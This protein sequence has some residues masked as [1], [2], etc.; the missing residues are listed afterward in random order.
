MKPE[1][2]RKPNTALRQE[3]R[4]RGWSQ[5]EVARQL[6]DIAYQ[7]VEGDVVDFSF[8][9]GVTIDMVSKWE[10][11]VYV[12]S[13]FYQKRLCQLFQR[14]AAELGLMDDLLETVEKVEELTV[15][16]QVPEQL[17]IKTTLQQTYDLTNTNTILTPPFAFSSIEILERLAQALA[18]P[19]QI[20]EATLLGLEQAVKDCW[21]FRPDILGMISPDF[22]QVPLD[23][24]QKVTVLLSG[25]LLPS[26]RVR[27]CA[28]A[29]ELTQIIAWTL[30]EMRMFSQAQAYYEM[31]LVAARE[32]GDPLLEAVTLTRMSRVF[33]Y[34][35]QEEA[36]LPAIQHA[37]NLLAY[38]NASSTFSWI[39][40]E[41]ALGY[42]RN[43]Q[44]Y[45]SLKTLDLVTHVGQPDNQEEDPYWVGFEE[46]VRAGFLGSCYTA[47]QQFEKAEVCYREALAQLH[48]SSRINFRHRRSLLLVNLATVLLNKESIEEACQLSQ[49]ALALVDQSKSPLVLQHVV[50]FKRKLEPWKSLAAVESFVAQFEQIQANLLKRN[51][52]TYEK[53]IMP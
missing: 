35:A 9:G 19:T 2:S 52:W 41:E 13:L 43:E 10:L 8:K 53:G 36:V 17:Q 39:C 20:D 38:R 48:P 22:L 11:G 12:P 4:L 14:T 45:E 18:R 25:S 32:T 33:K 28:I 26:T 27:L 1:N 50:K 29:C 51:K 31:A 7:D 16:C 24:L 46:N 34:C 42:A 44:A 15:A 5:G 37:R 3:R 40:A 21:R 47:L 6:N 23:H 30:Y 49:E